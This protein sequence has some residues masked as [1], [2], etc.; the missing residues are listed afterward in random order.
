MLCNK[1]KLD[2]VLQGKLVSAGWIH[3]SETSN[4]KCDKIQNSLSPVGGRMRNDVS[5]SDAESKTAT[6]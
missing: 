6:A 5:T 4:S 2:I 3:L 1:E